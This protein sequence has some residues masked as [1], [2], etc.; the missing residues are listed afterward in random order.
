MGASAQSHEASIAHMVC[1]KHSFPPSNLDRNRSGLR[2][3]SAYG[4][5]PDSRLGLGASSEG[6]RAPIKVK[7]KNDTVGLGVHSKHDLKVQGRERS[8][9]AK[10]TRL[11]DLENKKKRAILQEIFYGNEDVERFLYSGCG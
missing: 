11:R 9:D 4:W 5:D 10:Q 7:M 6:I 3:L 2:Y 1:L 8:L